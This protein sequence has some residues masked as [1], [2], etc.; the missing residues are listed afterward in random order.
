MNRLTRTAIVLGCSA[1]LLP[2]AAS[3]AQGPHPEHKRITPGEKQASDQAMQAGLSQL[4]AAAGAI[5]QGGRTQAMADL[6]SAESSMT[7]ALPIYH[8]HREEAMHAADRAMKELQRNGKK[9]QARSAES[10]AKAISDADAALR[11]N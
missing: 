3:F 4:Q 5:Q 1:L 6:Q 11:T 10:V 8:G 9:A 2:A 7:S